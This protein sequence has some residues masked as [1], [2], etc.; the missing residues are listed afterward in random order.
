MFMKSCKRQQESHLKENL[1]IEKIND[2][3]T[4]QLEN[5]NPRKTKSQIT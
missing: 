4:K 2:F 1:E 3:I 5:K